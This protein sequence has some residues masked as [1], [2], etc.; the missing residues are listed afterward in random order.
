MRSHGTGPVYGIAAAAGLLSLVLFALVPDRRQS[1]DRPALGIRHLAEGF[2]ASWRITELRLLLA[3]YGAG[4]LLVTLGS[5]FEPLFFRPAWHP[6][7]A[8]LHVQ[9]G[10]PGPAHVA[11]A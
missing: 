9:W 6:G 7:Q 4:W 1:G 10:A 8:P 5:I 3:L 11:S 2:R